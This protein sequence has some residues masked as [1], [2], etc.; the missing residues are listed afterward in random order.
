MAHDPTFR[1]RKSHA[2]KAMNLLI[3]I[4]CLLLLLN[5]C[6]L[7][8]AERAL[9]ACHRDAI[10][11]LNNPEAGAAFAYVE[12]CMRA[13]GYTLGPCKSEDIYSFKEP[14]CYQRST[15]F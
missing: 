13:K 12:P 10:G 4:F 11:K 7:E 2:G 6:N 15:W 14:T 9:A 5:G 8:S 1:L 3:L